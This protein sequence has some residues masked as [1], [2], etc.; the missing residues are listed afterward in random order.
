MQN[1]QTNKLV[2]RSIA[3]AVLFC[4]RQCIGLRGDNESEVNGDEAGQR[5]IG[6]RG[7]FMATL[8]LIARHD[9]VL[10]QHLQQPK[11]NCKYTSPQIQNELIEVIGRDIIQKS[12]L[13]EVK[14]ARYFSVLADEV[15]SHNW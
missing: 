3:E 13:D 1:V 14:E 7:N 8:H 12:I 9:K 15:T 11:G 10:Q 4:T 2:V 5:M 6:N